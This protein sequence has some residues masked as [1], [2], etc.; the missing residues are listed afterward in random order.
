LRRQ[1][2]LAG[3]EHFAHRWNP[4]LVQEPDGRDVDAS[5]PLLHSATSRPLPLL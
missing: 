2:P 1:T 4:G 3:V 5:A